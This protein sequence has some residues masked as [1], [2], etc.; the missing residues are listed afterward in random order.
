MTP[1]EKF[2]SELCEKSFLPFWSFPS[3][4]GKKNKELCDVLVVCENS[5]IIISIK[6]IKVS[7]HSDENIQYERWQKKAIQSSIDQIYG[8]ERFLKNVDEITLSDRVTKNQLP[9]YSNRE[10]FRIAI[11]FGRKSEYSLETGDFGNGF[12][13]VFDEQSTFTVLSE[14]DTITDFVNYLRAKEEFLV[15]KT[16]MVPREVDFLALYLS[17]SLE[18]DFLPDTV[19]LDEGMW[20]DYVKSPDYEYWKK[21][22]PQSYIWDEIVS[23]LHTIHIKEKG[24]YTSISDLERA[25]RIIALEPRINRMELGMCLIDAIEKE[26]RGRMMPPLKD[27]DHSYVFM[28]LNHKNWESRDKELQLRCLI[29]RKENKNAPKVIGISIGRSPENE[30]IFDIAYF[31]IPELNDKMLESIEAAK[32]ELGYFK[33]PSISRSKDMRK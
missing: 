28:P 10:I 24:D 18:F 5:I 15:N 2:V 8:A 20:E 19:I 30:Y 11:A 22:I 1:S 17:T 27:S 4:L 3:P 7:E 6:D 12:V 16:I 9:P 25:T 32:Q 21:E 23:Q 33:N 14:L 26:V 13:H 31:D 29:A